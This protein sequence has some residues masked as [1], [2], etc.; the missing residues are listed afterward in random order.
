MPGGADGRHR[1]VELEDY[2]LPDLGGGARL[3][4]GAGVS[5]IHADGLRASPNRQVGTQLG[6]IWGLAKAPDC[7]GL[8]VDELARIDWSRVKLD[9]W[10]AILA[11][12]GHYRRPTR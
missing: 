5:H 4:Y 2:L 6:R 10:L 11:A 8:A 3:G 12:T 9:E 1:R 7:T